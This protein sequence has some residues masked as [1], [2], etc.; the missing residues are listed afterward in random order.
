MRMYAEI[1]EQQEKI[2]KAAEEA[3]RTEEQYKPFFEPYN[4]ASIEPFIKAY[5]EEKA[6]L[7]T[8]GKDLSMRDAYL[9][10]Y[11]E[12][13]AHKHLWEIQQRKLLELQCRWRA[14]FID[15]PEITQAYDFEYWG[16]F[17][18]RCPFLP[19]ITPDEYE[20]YIQYLQSDEYERQ[21]IFFIRWQ[22]Y[23]LLIQYDDDDVPG[24]PYPAWYEYCDTVLGDE[25]KHLPDILGE[26]EKKYRK[27]IR[28]K[29]AAEFPKK[30]PEEYKPSLYTSDSKVMEAFIRQFE[31]QEMLRYFLAVQ[32]SSKRKE[33]DEDLD[34]AVAYL[35]KIDEPIPMGEAKDWREGILQLAEQVKRK[36]LVR[37]CE[38]AY[39]EYRRRESMGLPQELTASEKEI[40]REERRRELMWNELQDAKRLM[41][42]NEER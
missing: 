20:R 1:R 38:N 41:E 42:N 29:R 32:A 24:L 35:K 27:A 18:E 26:E 34:A 3:L 39:K 30:N 13:E 14:G 40:A 37:G 7:M 10:L 9:L 33:Q 22:N 36:I 25:W 19:P 12:E 28:E 17:I 5:A 11:D 21:E 4:I 31:S 15:L 23:D 2:R 16:V 6:K 8:D